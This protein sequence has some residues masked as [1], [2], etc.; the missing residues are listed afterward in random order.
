MKKS[1]IIC[2]SLAIFFVIWT[3]L[4]VSGCTEMFDLYIYNFII[5]F[6]SN[7]FDSFFKFITKFGNTNIV[8]IITFLFLVIKRNYSSFVL[9]FLALITPAIMFI[10]KSI[11]A[12]ARPNIL[13]IIEVGGYSFPSGHSMISVSIYG[14]FIY[15]VFKHV[16]NLVLKYL[17]CS[18]LFLLILLI[19]ISR[20]YLG[21]HYP[22]DVVGGYLVS[23]V[24]LI[25]IINYSEKLKK[26]EN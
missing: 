13:R 10:M 25:I 7:I 22:S 12:R 6:R 8:F 14:Y 4:V 19:G 26:E 20:I 2:I 23:S 1:R 16:N 11:I 5:K 17:I 18:I 24:I 21:V 3:I 9:C 15:Y